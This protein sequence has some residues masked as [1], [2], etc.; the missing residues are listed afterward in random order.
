MVIKEAVEMGW[1]A[2]FCPVRTRPYYITC[3]KERVPTR[4]PI[5]RCLGLRNPSLQ[6]SEFGFVLE[7]PHLRYVIPEVSADDDKA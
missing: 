5:C 6:N 1:L 3:S 7:V 2:P 4:Y